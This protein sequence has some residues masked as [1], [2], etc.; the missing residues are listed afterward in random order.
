MEHYQEFISVLH[1]KSRNLRLHIFSSS[2]PSFSLKL[3]ESSFLFFPFL[4]KKFQVISLYKSGLQR[5][6]ISSM[7]CCITCKKVE[8][9]M[10]LEALGWNQKT[11]MFW[12]PAVCSDCYKAVFQNKY[13]EKPESKS[14]VHHLLTERL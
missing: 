2:L 13:S 12:V 11:N 6:S 8:R 9:Q 10:N 5:K 3:K 14:Q 1:L 4:E 7:F